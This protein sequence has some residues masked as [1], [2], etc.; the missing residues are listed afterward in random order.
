MQSAHGPILKRTAN[1]VNQARSASSRGLVKHHGAARA[2]QP[3][4]RNG[5]KC[6]NGE[7]PP[8]PSQGRI[9]QENPLTAPSGAFAKEAPKRARPADLVPRHA[10]QLHFKAVFREGSAE[11]FAVVSNAVGGFITKPEQS[12]QAGHFA[13]GEIA[14]A[15]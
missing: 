7:S 6:A 11:T 8:R 4:H 10:R 5:N 2:A 15:F 12:D 1:A 3:Q 14:I 9:L 13:P